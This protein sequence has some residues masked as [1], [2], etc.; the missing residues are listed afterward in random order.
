MTPDLKGVQ[1]F[2]IGLEEN[3]HQQINLPIIVKYFA[4]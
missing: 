1:F 3:Y 2:A 4:L